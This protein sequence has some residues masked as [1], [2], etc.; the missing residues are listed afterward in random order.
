[1]IKMAANR[2]KTVMCH[3]CGKV[4]RDDKLKR[5]MD[6]KHVG[7]VIEDHHPLHHSMMKVSKKAEMVPT[8]Y[9]NQEGEAPVPIDGHKTPKE[10]LEFELKR[11]YETYKKNVEMGE[12]ISV[13]I[14]EKE[15]ME[16]SLSKQH[17]YCLELFRAQCPTVDVEKA[18]LRPW[19]KSF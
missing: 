2:N 4:M 15:I 3:V 6:S 9:T 10:M 18:E 11:N 14:K 1:M 16:E 8:D 17:K 19:Q 5:H 7:C 13:I 12:L